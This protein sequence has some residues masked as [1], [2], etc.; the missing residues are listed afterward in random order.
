MNA[1]TDL[2][3]WSVAVNSHDFPTDGLWL[4][5]GSDFCL[6]R[7]RG[8]KDRAGHQ[9][10]PGRPHCR[11]CTPLCVSVT[12]RDTAW[13]LFKLGRKNPLATGDLPLSS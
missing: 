4:P 7:E 2:Y 13:N 6:H 3:E 11:R 9:I 8:E 10:L 12:L 5:G 1:V